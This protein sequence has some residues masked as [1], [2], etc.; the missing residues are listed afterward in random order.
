MPVNA[1]S[2]R[3]ADAAVYQVLSTALNAD[4]GE[5]VESWANGTASDDRCRY[6]HRTNRPIP[7]H[8]ADLTSERLIIPNGVTVD[9]TAVSKVDNRIGSITLADGSTISGPFRIVE[10]IDRRNMRGSRKMITLLL[11]RVT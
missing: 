11:E 6:V 4:S 10:I 8:D 2:R 3:L 1:V 9:G 7:G 5:Q